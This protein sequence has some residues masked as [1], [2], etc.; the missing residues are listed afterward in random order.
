M[1]NG[2]TNDQIKAMFLFIAVGTRV[3]SARVVLILAMLLAF[4]LFAW[5]LAMPGWERIAAAT[6][7]AVLVFL[8]ATRVDAGQSKARADITPK[9]EP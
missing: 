4:S 7:F 1:N 5:A 3:L 9:D 8:P 6:I 2:Q